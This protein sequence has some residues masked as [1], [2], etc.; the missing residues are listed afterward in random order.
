MIKAVIVDD[1]QISLEALAS[2][3]GS[4][5]PQVTILKLFDNPK[6]AQSEIPQLQPDLLFVDIEMPQINGFTMLKN[7]S[8][9]AFEVIFTTAYSQYA[10]EA[11]HISALDF[12]LKPIDSDELVTA[13]KKMETKLFQGP[14]TP[15][16]LEDQLLLYQQYRTQPDQLPKIAL[17]ILNGLEFVDIHDIIRVEGEN[18]YSVF[19]L[20]GGKKMVVSRTLKEVDKMLSVCGFVR[21]HKSSIINLKHLSRYIK[22]EGGTIILSDG[23]EVEVSRRSKPEFLAR[24]AKTGS[25]L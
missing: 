9:I 12:L 10:I 20:A 16:N 6:K 4:L 13:V 11:L 15:K 2:K 22:G 8:P 17:P 18:V 1:E 24:I 21:V 23:S 25:F 3:I 5:C 19:H 14:T 7:M